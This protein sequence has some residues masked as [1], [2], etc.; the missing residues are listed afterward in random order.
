MSVVQ[1][2]FRHLAARADSLQEL[3]EVATAEMESK[4]P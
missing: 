2:D 3:F 1:R 4:S